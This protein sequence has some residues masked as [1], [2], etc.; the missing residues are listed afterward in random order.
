LSG[1]ARNVL[2]LGSGNL[3][4]Q[5]ISILAVPVITRLYDP[6]QFGAFALVFS[7]VAVLYP[8]ATLRLNSAIL[9]PHAE[10]EADDL[11]LLSVAAVAVVALALMP[12]LALAL[13]WLAPFDAPTRGLLWFLVAG[14]MIHG[15]VHCLEFWLL[16]HQRFTAMS[17][18]AVGESVTD[19]VTA[20]L[21]GLF[22]GGQAI[23]LVLGRLF[24][25]AVHL[26]ILARSA[27]SF[28]P[29]PWQRP[30][31]LSALRAALH[32]HRR[33]PLYSTW[34]FLFASGGRELP[35]LL[36]AGLFSTAA[37]GMYA[38]GVRVLGFPVLVVGDAVAKVFFRYATGLDPEPLRLLEATRLM[39]RGAIYLMFPPMLV[40]A[41]AGPVLFEI[42]F[43]GEWRDAGRFAQVL[44]MSY[45]VTF[46]YKVLSIFFDLRDR[47]S[48]RLLFDGLQLTLC[49]LA[50]FVG[51]AAGGVSGAV[52]GMLLANLVTHGAAVVYLLV[53]AG[54]SPADA[55]AQI[56]RAAAGLAPLA[57]MAGVASL[58]QPGPLWVGVLLVVGL[59]VQPLWLAWREPDL[60]AYARG[61]LR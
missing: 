44:A 53:L 45:L 55:A 59:L 40:L 8:I 46:V 27:V 1:F 35:T 30:T 61:K 58:S 42:G 37:A 54:L 19:R 60:L 18:G 49:V 10:Q 21:V 36:F 52:W 33:F 39:A 25:G 15:V 41:V 7:L 17:W 4:A 14:V 5:L 11:L 48:M 56:G 43:G 16:R 31:S 13:L 32:R 24:G 12:L 50:I 28:S 6:A 20:I 47:Q 29:A 3:A 51:G 38:L 22:Q 57:A 23:G 26:F 9:L 34:A 2:A